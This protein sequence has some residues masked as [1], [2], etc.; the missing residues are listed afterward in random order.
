MKKIICY[1]DSNTFGF[2]PENGTRY[3]LDYRWTSLLS[4]IVGE[5][6]LVVEEGLNNRT[7]FFVNSDGLRQS[8]EKYL[9]VCLQNHKNFDIF[10]LALGTNDL[11]YQFRIDESKAIDGL[12]KLIAIIKSFNSKSRIIVV[13]PVILDERVLNGRFS[14]Q[15][16]QDSINAS[17]WIQS[18]YE[19]V[20]KSENCELLDVNKVVSVSDVDGL[21]FDKQSH[22]VIAQVAAECIICDK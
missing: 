8:G 16:N 19:K 15:F 5:E 7:G 9:P 18:V 17:K 21:H 3:G 6:Y 11:Q 14:H 12:K 2:N 22:K 1:G 10:I 13:P 20:V 4:G